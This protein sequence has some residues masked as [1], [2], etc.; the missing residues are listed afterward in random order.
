MQTL[1][2]TAV[3]ASGRTFEMDF[4]LHPDTRS[5][6]DVSRMV[7]ALLRAV[8]DSVEAGGEVSDG[9][10]LQALAMAMAVRSRLIDVDPEV[11]Q[12]LSHAL[13]DTAFGAAEDARS[14]EASRQ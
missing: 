10:V 2:Y 14:Y 1:K 8:N 13:L 12:R 4:P 11:V 5:S 6:A 7:T 3:A 9:D